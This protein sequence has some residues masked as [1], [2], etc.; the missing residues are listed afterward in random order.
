M[1]V[2]N[3]SPVLVVDDLP[4]CR[5]WLS[6]ALAKAFPGAVVETADSVAGGLAA[7]ASRPRLALIDLGLPDGDGLKVLKAMREQLPDAIPVIATVFD[8]DAHLFAAL[9]AGAQGYVLKDGALD[10]LAE[11]LRGI[12]DGQPPLS[13]S[14]A[15]RL[16]KHFAGPAPAQPTRSITGQDDALTPRESEV[17]KLVAKGLSVPRIAELLSLSRHT[18]G[19]YL[20]D[21]Y[22]KL[23]ISSRAEAT[24]ETANHR[25][26]RRPHDSICV[27]PARPDD[28]AMATGNRRQCGTRATTPACGDDLPG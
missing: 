8:D 27:R 19:G 24:L 12:V 6:A 28:L 9:S 1:E 7:L 14:I 16:L 4:H 26:F 5:D 23:N 2:P 21:V 15:R 20:K 25:P 3:L 10:T 18:V 11:L 22:R 13:A 17:L